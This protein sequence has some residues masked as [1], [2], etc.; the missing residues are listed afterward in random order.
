MKIVLRLIPIQAANAISKMLRAVD[1]SL[2]NP[3]DI[4]NINAKGEKLTIIPNPVR[5]GPFLVIA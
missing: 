2:L 5:L 4:T 3:Y 1:E